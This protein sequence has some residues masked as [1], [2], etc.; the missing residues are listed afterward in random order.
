LVARVLEAR[1]MDVLELGAEALFRPQPNPLAADLS[2]N[3][4][5]HVRGAISPSECDRILR[6]V[7]EARGHWTPCFEGVQFTLGR[8][9][10]AHLEEDREDEY[11]ASAEASDRVVERFLPG[12][13]AMLRSVASLVAGKSVVHRTG[14]CGP[15]IHIFPA[16]AWLSEKGGDVHFDTEGLTDAQ[17]GARCPAFTI[18]LMLQAPDRGGALRVWDR[19]DDGS[20]EEEAGE[21]K[22]VDVVY[23]PGDLVVLDSYRLHQIQP[24]DG[25]RDRISATIHAVRDR[26]WET[27]F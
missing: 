8:A 4:A 15:G 21:A 22:S 17:R 11:F 2:A 23:R 24:F 16:H 25:D 3:L 6:A 7:H 14:W 18:V 10:Y 5:I 12:F 13:Q 27:W 19:V 9:W 1:S 20:G 26:R